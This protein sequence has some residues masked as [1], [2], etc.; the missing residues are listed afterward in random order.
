MLLVRRH[1][2][3]LLVRGI[4]GIWDAR[5][6]SAGAAPNVE[7]IKDLRLPY[8]VHQRLEAGKRVSYSAFTPL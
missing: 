2:C 4:G 5:P 3:Y 8:S 1:Y 6:C 7:S